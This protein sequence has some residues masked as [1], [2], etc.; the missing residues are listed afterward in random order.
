MTTYTAAEVRNRILRKLGVLAAGE[1]ASSEDAAL[2]D[3][4][5]ADVHA[6]LDGLSLVSWPLSAVPGNLVAGY[7]NIVA[8]QVGAEFGISLGK[9]QEMGI[10]RERGIRHIR[11]Q[12]SSGWSGE[13]TEATYY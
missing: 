3:T 10:S 12:V 9:L 2:V 6:E 11:K 4:E 5:L 7:V 13:A 1:T 8:E